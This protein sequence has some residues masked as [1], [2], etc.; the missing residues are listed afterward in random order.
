MPSVAL[1]R[2]LVSTLTPAPAVPALSRSA[3]KLMLTRYVIEF[4]TESYDWQKHGAIPR[5]VGVSAYSIMD[6]L[7]L[8]ARWLLRSDHWPPIFEITTNY[9]LNKTEY[10]W[11]LHPRGVPVW[12]GLWMPAITLLYGPDDGHCIPFRP[13]ARNAMLKDL[14]GAK[15][16][17]EHG[18]G[19]KASPATS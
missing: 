2:H 19:G 14:T 8:T 7:N 12:R 3:K 18:E 6:A 10:P 11:G 1:T 17:A 9:D 16:K 5:F 15:I 4:D 13:G